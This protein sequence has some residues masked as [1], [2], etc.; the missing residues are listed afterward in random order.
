MTLQMLTMATQVRLTKYPGAGYVLYPDEEL[1]RLNAGGFTT[2]ASGTLEINF[3]ALKTGDHFIIEMSYGECSCPL[4]AELEVCVPSVVPANM[5]DFIASLLG[6]HP[7]L[8][9]VFS[10]TGTG[11]ATKATLYVSANVPRLEFSVS[12]HPSPKITSY[13]FAGVPSSEGYSMP[14][15]G[16]AVV[17][18]GGDFETGYSPTGD[19]ANLEMFLG[20]RAHPPGSTLN[21]CCD[22]STHCLLVAD[23]CTAVQIVL[24]QAYV[25]VA[26]MSR[27]RLLYNTTTG[28]FVLQPYGDTTVISAGNNLA[29]ENIKIVRTSG[30]KAIVYSL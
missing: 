9:G 1:R 16:T 8:A 24:A 20:V 7:A 14:A 18:R 25:P 15:Y 29:V 11:T 17:V 3:G 27:I 12:V 19:V 2:N 4:L 26:G 13:S 30:D 21:S 10:F 22:C 6:V 28:L 23:C 5:G